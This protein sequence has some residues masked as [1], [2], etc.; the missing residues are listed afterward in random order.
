MAAALP[1]QGQH[2]W[3]PSAMGSVEALLQ[4]LLKYLLILAWRWHLLL[5]LTVALPVLS[6]VV[7]LLQ[8]QR[9]VQQQVQALYMLA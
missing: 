3:H 5:R 2:A 8:K 1:L 9:A 7:L 6:A 4:L